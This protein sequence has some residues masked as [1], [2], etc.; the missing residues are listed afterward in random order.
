MKKLTLVVDMYGCPNRCKHC[1]LGHMP[2]RTMSENSDTLLVDYFKPYFDSITYYS[3]VREP[4]YCEDYR[5]R[6]IRDNEISVQE[7]PM[8][9]D[10]ASFYRLVRDKEYVKFLKEVGTTGVQLTFFGLETMTDYCIGREGAYQEL[11][12]ATEILLENEIAPTWQAFLYEDNKEEVVQLLDVIRERRLRERCASF[13]KE[14]R[15]FV[16]EGSCDGENAKRYDVRI[17][18]E[19]I[20]QEI[21]PY[22]NGYENGILEE[23]ECVRILSE[24]HEKIV[25]EPSDEIVLNVDNEMNVYYNYTHMTKP[26]II[27][28][29]LKEDAKELVRKITQC[30]TFALNALK[31]V[32]HSELVAKYGD[33]TS[34]RV[35][36]QGDYEMYMMN[37]YLEDCWKE[38][39]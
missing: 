1:W 21:A 17:R 20:P 24:N 35:F 33:P 11:L 6:W 32:S 13:G 34:T 19:N 2:N 29:V 8:R 22:Y 39:A 31:K 15:F 30:D 14:F 18:K 12:A 3:W 37:R 27:G 4:D 26:W 5:Q 7:K 10:L 38:M 16:H 25:F 36:S 23:R 28:N 9:F